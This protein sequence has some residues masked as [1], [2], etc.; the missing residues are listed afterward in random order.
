MT[1]KS[2]EEEFDE[3][4]SQENTKSK[5]IFKKSSKKEDGKIVHLYII[6]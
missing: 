3:N 5:I 4:D 6:K 2:K 1:E